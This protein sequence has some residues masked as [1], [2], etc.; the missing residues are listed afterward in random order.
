ML[1]RLL[2]AAVAAALLGLTA[3]LP[4]D[5]P[6]KSNSRLPWESPARSVEPV[7]RPPAGA[8]ELL[9][10][11]DIGTSQLESFFSGQP[12]SP[13]EEDVLVKLLYHL[14]RLGLENL[15]RWRKRDVSWDRVA[16]APAENRVKTFHLRGRAKRVEKQPLLPEQVELFEFNHY[17]RVT[18]GSKARRFT[19]SSPRGGCL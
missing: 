18:L 19:R 7:L 1:E 11:F 8:A 16:A 12:L 5:E 4:A 6:V 13:T 17:Y 9:E 3:Q 14:P 15:Q 2:L 10:R